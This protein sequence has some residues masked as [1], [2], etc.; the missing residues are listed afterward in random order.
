M[1]FFNLFDSM[2]KKIK[3]I[4]LKEINLTYLNCVTKSRVT[5]FNVI[6]E[7]QRLEGTLADH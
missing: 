4:S 7:W 5:I 1:V 3:K 2:E 6:T